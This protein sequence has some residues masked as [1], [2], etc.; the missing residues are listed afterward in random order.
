MTMGG[1]AYNEL[2]ETQ[3]APQSE[4]GTAEAQLGL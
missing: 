4:L 3:G 1:M 2:C